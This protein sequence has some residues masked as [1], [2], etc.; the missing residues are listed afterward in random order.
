MSIASK[1]TPAWQVAAMGWLARFVSLC[2]GF[3]VLRLNIKA[4]GPDR[5]A[6][7]ALLLGMGSWFAL[8]DLGLGTWLQN[9]ISKR[10]A[11][12]IQTGDIE[13]ETFTIIATVMCL[14]ASVGWLLAPW[15]ADWLLGGFD[16]IA[17][18]ERVR[19]WRIAV[20]FQLGGALGQVYT[21]VLFAQMRGVA[22]HLI[23]ISI[24]LIMAAVV[25]VVLRYPP[26]ALSSL[27]L[28]ALVPATLMA[29]LNW[30]LYLNFKLSWPRFH[31]F[32]SSLHA[33]FYFFR[34]YLLGTVTLN[35]DLI[36]AAR[37]LPH[38]EMTSYSVA[39][40]LFNVVLLLY[41]SILTAIW[42][43]CSEAF[44]LNDYKS[45]KKLL[46]KMVGVGLVGVIFFTLILILA[47]PY[48]SHFL[49]P[50]E[51]LLLPLSLLLAMGGGQ[52][53]RVW[54]DAHAVVLQSCDAVGPLFYFNLLQAAVSVSAQLFLV[55][56][57][58]LLGIPVGIA[59]SFLLSVGW[60]LPLLTQRLLRQPAVISI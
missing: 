49:S 2:T 53:L 52:L 20:V 13:R 21:K 32:R 59:L 12:G 39:F 33:G 29:L 31:T 54:C 41:G 47:K 44:A 9:N 25:V 48:I 51:E 38:A 57:I 55:D 16:F 45:I 1:G 36:I 37:Y 30:G 26:V 18:A 24:N 14:V 42:P 8:A 3:G 19:L 40:R 58:G 11:Q 56:K 43:H 5:F 17:P 34:F 4:L 10:R 60:G 35:C 23:A 27:V 46:N 6:A 22:A 15:V 28:A 7:L 50:R